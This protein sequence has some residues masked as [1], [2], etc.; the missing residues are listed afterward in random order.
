MRYAG[1]R[2]AAR[3][4]LARRR[5]GCHCDSTGHC[6][7]RTNAAAGSP[8]SIASSLTR[9]N[10]DDTHRHDRRLDTR[11]TG[12]AASMR[13]RHRRPGLRTAGALKAV[14]DAD[15]TAQDNATVDVAA[16]SPAE[17]PIAGV[18]KILPGRQREI[19]FVAGSRASHC[20]RIVG[21]RYRVSASAATPA[22]GIRSNGCGRVRPDASGLVSASCT[23]SPRADGRIAL[24]TRARRGA[25]MRRTERSSRRPR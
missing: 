7:S 5:A 19:A 16:Q 13:P 11:R 12:T 9:R 20:A 2:R 23:Q 24:S 17:H 1:P 15:T 14:P 22:A 4:P 25:T 3:G 8:Q 18:R 6:T 21:C 10:D